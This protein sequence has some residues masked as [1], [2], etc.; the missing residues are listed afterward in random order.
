MR[1]PS[2]LFSSLFPH[3]CPAPSPR[4]CCSYPTHEQSLAAGC[5]GCCSCPSSRRRCACSLSSLSMSSLLPI[6]TPRAV[7]RGG[8]WGCCG[9]GPRRP[10]AVVVVGRWAVL[11]R[12]CR[13]CLCWCPCPHPLSLP[14][15]F[16]LSLP[17]SFSFSL[18][19]SFSLSLPLS[20][21]LSSSSSRPVVVVVVPPAPH[22]PCPRYSRCSPRKRSLAA[23]LR[24]R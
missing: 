3:R 22:R 23:G 18:P 10:L 21:S 17:L 6:S 12:P 20:F 24:V 2:S 9:G 5:G 13:P 16:S 14:L 8:G 15:S 19:L 7:A 11:G 4:R 1:L